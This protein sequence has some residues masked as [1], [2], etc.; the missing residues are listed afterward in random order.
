MYAKPSL[1]LVLVLHFSISSAASGADEVDFAREIAPI[2]EERCLFCHGEDEQESGLRLDRRAD[3]LRGGDYGLP[4]VVP[5]NPEKSYLIEVVSHQDPDL[6]MPP[7]EDRIPDEEI[8]LLTRWIKEGAIWPGQM[9]TVADEKSDHWSFQPIERPRVPDVAS[10]SAHPAKGSPLSPIDA[11]LLERLSMRELS[12]ST[13]AEPR[14]LLR[15]ISIVLTGLAP[16]PEETR[17]FLNAYADDSDAAY[18]Q[19][20]DRLLGSPHFGERWAQHWLDVIRWAETNGSESNMYRKNAWIYR[21]YVIRAFNED[22]PYD[23]FIR[24]QIAGDTMG[25]GD[26]TGYLV[27]GPHVPVATVG[28]EPAA[29]RQA[30]ADRMDE[31]LQTVGASALGVT[32]GCAR[33]HNHKFDP[34][35]IRDYYA[36][37][38]VFQDIEFGSRFPELAVDH[39]RRVRGEQLYGEIAEL[40]ELLQQMGPW[41]EDWIGYRELH[42]PTSTTQKVRITFGWNGVRLDELEIFGPKERHRNLAL[43]SE[44]TKSFSPREMAVVRAELH[45]VNDGRYGTEGWG[46]RARRG[47]NRSRGSNS[48]S[49][50]RTISIAFG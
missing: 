5:G 8:A 35:S 27:S 49:R 50:S 9:D 26:A 12:F 3:V 6:K 11:F 36:M 40:H 34:I 41:E 33:C 24:E 29:R 15:R 4:A 31:I 1:F 2:L 19:L 25:Q 39:P 28:Q 7:D 46:S 37:S 23:E 30:R 42:F 47:A 32:I 20:V 45:K 38:A 14:A 43:A 22:K 44:G 10:L 18:A 48:H 13:P 17:A 21:D 16:T